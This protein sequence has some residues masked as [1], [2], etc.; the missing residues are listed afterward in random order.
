[1]TKHI[2][3]LGFLAACTGTAGEPGAPGPTGPMGA[4][5]SAASVDGVAAGGALAGA[6][7]DP[8]IAAGA[9]EP[10]AF[11]TIPAVEVYAS[12][13]SIVTGVTVLEWTET[14][15]NA[16]MH[17]NVNDPSRLIAPIDGLYVIT[18]ELDWRSVAAPGTFR[19]ASLRLN[20]TNHQVAG[21]QVA[22]VP[23]GVD[24]S[25]TSHSV[26]TTLKLA[27]GDYVELYADQDT[28]GAL[29]IAEAFLQMTWISP[30]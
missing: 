17:D 27:A 2:V 25:F 14:R 5:G 28:G 19:L 11:G 4:A 8:T 12:D 23:T 13:V 24:G 6:Y 3:V 29:A 21:S 20:G 26:V 7:P 15:D 22:P 18:A 30:G 1:M 16:N 10:A 9:I